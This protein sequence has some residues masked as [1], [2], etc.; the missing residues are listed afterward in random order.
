MKKTLISL[1]LLLS[2]SVAAPA[3]GIHKKLPLLEDELHRQ[4]TRAQAATPA[5]QAQLAAMQ[6]QFTYVKTRTDVSGHLPAK[7][8]SV[9]SY[10]QE[11]TYLRRIS[12]VQKS[13]NAN[14]ALAGYTFVAPVPTDLVNLSLDNYALLHAFLKGFDVAQVVRTERVH[15]FTL[16]VQMKGPARG[17]LELWLDVPTKK[18]YLMSDNLYTT[19][20]GK[21]G[22]HLK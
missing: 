17:S 3:Q 11:Q 7:T 12:Q 16:A 20:A 18:V 19:A 1:L 13:V 2:V 15:P 4:V 22:L 21:Y 9:L 5:W 14:K 6:K 8:P 10:R